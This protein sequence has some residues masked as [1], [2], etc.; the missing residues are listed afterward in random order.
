MVDRIRKILKQ[1]S[2]KEHAQVT[3]IVRL[4][5]V[6]TLE[7]LDIKK[8]QGVDDVYRVRKGNFRIIF[9]KT[10]DDNNKLI[11]IERRTDTTYNAFYL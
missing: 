10:A 3:E 2:T 6:N 8:L 5:A 11:A 1:L 4:I 7:G 9:Q